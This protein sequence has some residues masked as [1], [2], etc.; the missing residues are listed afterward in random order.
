MGRWWMLSLI[1]R[2]WVDLRVQGV[3]PI[4]HIHGDLRDYQTVMVWL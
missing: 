1:H 2:I 4:R 3:L